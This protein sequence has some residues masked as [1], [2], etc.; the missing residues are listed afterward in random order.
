MI[1]SSIIIITIIYEYLKLFIIII[2]M[3]IIM[4]VFYITIYLRYIINSII[5][6]N[7]ILTAYCYY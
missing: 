5:S 2:S 6:S 4:R 3:N 1:V 7:V